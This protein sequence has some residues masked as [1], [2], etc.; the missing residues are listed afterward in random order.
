MADVET[1]LESTW[2]FLEPRLKHLLDF[3]E[4]GIKPNEYMNIYTAVYN[5]CQRRSTGSSQENQIDFT[6][7]LLYV[8]LENFLSEYLGNLFKEKSKL[9]L[10]SLL[11]FYSHQ[12]DRFLQGAKCLNNIF[13]YLNRHWIKRQNIEDKKSVAEI[14]SLCLTS[15]KEYAFEPNSEDILKASNT[16]VCNQRDGN[17]S[18]LQLIKLLSDSLVAIGFDHHDPSRITLEY[19]RTKFEYDYCEVI[20]SYYAK[21]CE[22]FLATHSIVEYMQKAETRLKE[23]EDRVQLCLH[24][25]SLAQVKKVCEDTLIAKYSVQFTEEFQALLDNDRVDDMSRMVTLLGRVPNGLDPLRSKFENHV[26]KLGFDS[27]NSVT[28]NTE[29]ALSPKVYIDSM[30]RVHEKFAKMV[31]DGFHNDSGFVASLDKACG[32]FMN[33]NQYCQRTSVTKTPELLARYSDL[34]LKKSQKT[35]EVDDVEGLLNSIMTVFKYVEDKD[36]FQKY[37][38]QTLAKRLVYGQSVSDD[39]ET[40][41]IGKLKNAC[42]FEYTSKLQKMFTD[43]SLSNNLNEGFKEKLKNSNSTLAKGFEFSVLVLGAA[44]WPFKPPPTKFTLPKE[45]NNPFERFNHYYSEKHSSRKLDIL[46]QHCKGEV[47]GDFSKATK[48]VYTLTVSTY[49]I[50]ILFLFNDADQISYEEILEKTSLTPEALFGP[51]QVLVKSKIITVTD[52]REVG[53][54]G[55]TYNLNTAYNN[56]KLRLNLNVPT[57]SETKTENDDVEKKIQEDRRLY[58][59]AAMVRI[60]KARKTMKHVALVNETIS[61][62]KSR[63]TPVVADIKHTIDLLLEKEYI[64][65]STDER[66]TFVYLA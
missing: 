37:Y 8:K 43:I 46:Y 16:I 12:W 9:N 60:M 17:K 31:H 11:Q 5:H 65:R 20:G 51:L 54:P 28:E 35:L 15:W 48:S 25:S 52:K 3:I 27:V 45:L 24:P 44:A 64:A 56:K 36:V 18:D 59:Q 62:L 19:Y 22:D 61:Q 57:K 40:S 2:E 55:T 29:E 6:G 32:E 38:S 63:F 39:L 10:E 50:G 66:D 33:R 42:G 14:F 4:V 34:L 47:K 23:E 21:E 26:K 58:I 41:M 7:G 13:S 49:Q 30:L 1:D 53:E